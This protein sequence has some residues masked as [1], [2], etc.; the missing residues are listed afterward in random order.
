MGDQTTWEMPSSATGGDH[1]GLDDPP[2]L[3]YCGWLEI[4]WKPRSL[5]SA[6]AVAELLG[7]PLADADVEDL[8]L[9]DQVGEGLHGLFQRRLVV[10]AVGLV[11]VDVVGLQPAQRA[12]GG[13]HGC[14][15]ATG[16]RSLW[17]LGPVGPKTLVKISSDS[18]R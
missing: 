7:G 14:A 5:A 4:S 17:P 18:R 9:P 6:C 3:E 15:C 12:V 16:R 1:L 10:V 13:L 8:A 2:E 11:E